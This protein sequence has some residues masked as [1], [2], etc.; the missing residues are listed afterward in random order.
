MADSTAEPSAEPAAAATTPADE[1]IATPQASESEKKVYTNNA[2][3]CLAPGNPVRAACIKLVHH[4]MFDN[5]IMTLIILNCVF[6]C[7]NDPLDK[8]E[9]SPLN[10]TLSAA[11]MIFGVLFFIE[12]IL[13]IIAMGFY[14]PSVKGKQS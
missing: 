5:F 7:L 6:L 13:K 2:L 14:T 11:S 1:A 8:D 10:V 4:K 3:W 9:N 12:M